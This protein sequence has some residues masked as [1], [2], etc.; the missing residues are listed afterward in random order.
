MTFDIAID[1]AELARL[2]QALHT[3]LTSRCPS[4]CCHY[5][6][7]LDCQCMFR[8]R[9]LSGLVDGD[10][11][12]PLRDWVDGLGLEMRVVAVHGHFGMNH[13]YWFT[14]RYQELQSQNRDYPSLLRGRCREQLQIDTYPMRRAYQGSDL[15]LP[16]LFGVDYLLSFRNDAGG[17]DPARPQLVLEDCLYLNEEFITREGVLARTPSLVEVLGYYQ[18]EWGWLWDFVEDRPLPMR[19]WCRNDGLANGSMHLPDYRGRGQARCRYAEQV[20]WW[21]CQRIAQLRAL[22]GAEQFNRFMRIVP[23]E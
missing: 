10:L 16:P 18:W 3:E 15:P 22:V 8:Y 19:D 9:S 23:P 14:Q 2:R 11:E 6:H 5:Q 4:E 20:Y 1:T 21:R 12:P 7:Q 13:N 17:Q